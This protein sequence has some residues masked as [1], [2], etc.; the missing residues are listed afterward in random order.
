MYK[1]KQRVKSSI[2]LRDNIEKGGPSIRMS[3]QKFP[4]TFL[5]DLLDHGHQ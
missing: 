5:G 2:T 3:N 4:L 1:Q